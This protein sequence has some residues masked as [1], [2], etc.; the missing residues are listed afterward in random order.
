LEHFMKKFKHI[1]AMALAAA[2]ATFAGNTPAYAGSEAHTHIGH[3]VSSWQDTPSERGLL[4]T[5]F[6]ESLV[7]AA[8][9]NYAVNAAGNLGAMKMH[10]GHVRHAI[11]PTL[12]SNGP[13]LGYGLIKAAEGATLHITLASEAA[14]ASAAV[15]SHTV[16]VVASL[17]AAVTRSKAAMIEADAIIAAPDTTVA[18]EHAVKL[19]EL[20]KAALMGMD[21]D[22][23]GKISW[24]NN[25]GGLKVA[26][27]HMGLILKAEGL[28]R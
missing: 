17:N 24:D 3:V 26:D 27:K 28:K 9:A 12:E 11:D 13:G 25:E 23:D 2:I 16:H 21:V 18:L 14:D 1:P 19:A 22:G 10:A 4:P 8:H 6:K 5:A 15:K 7:A 20:T